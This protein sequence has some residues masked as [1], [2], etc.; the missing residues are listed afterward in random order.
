MSS[1]ITLVAPNPGFTVETGSGN[2]YVANGGGLITGVTPGNDYADLLKAG[3][4]A[5]PFSFERP[6][7][8]SVYPYRV[9]RQHHQ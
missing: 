1:S 3:C 4:S 7:R 2:S 9:W 8:W 6:V 5:A